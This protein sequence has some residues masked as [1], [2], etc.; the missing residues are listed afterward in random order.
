MRISELERR[1]SE[2]TALL[3]AQQRLIVKLEKRGGDLTSAKIVFDSLRVSLFL[4][5]QDWH[6]ARCYVEPGIQSDFKCRLSA[7]DSK[8]SLV[9]VPNEKP[10]NYAARWVGRKPSDSFNLTD[11]VNTAEIV[12]DRG[13]EQSKSS[14]DDEFKFRPLTEEEKQEFVTS[15]NTDGKRIL[16]QLAD[17][18][19]RSDESA[20]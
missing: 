8:P 5:T 18:S 3:K 14:S 11:K 12:P 16:A 6:R 7:P 19:A 20:A 13:V 2:L 9:V 15:L 10:Q 17:K 1:V 4:A